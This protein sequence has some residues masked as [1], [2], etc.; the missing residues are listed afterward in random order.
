MCIDDGSMRNNQREEALEK[1]REDP[2]TT[3]MLV[4][5]LCGSTGLNLVCASRVI[6]LDV[7]WNPG[8]QSY[9]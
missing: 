4:S 9:S 3:V 6:L 1:I 8:K 7:W 2:E 5:L